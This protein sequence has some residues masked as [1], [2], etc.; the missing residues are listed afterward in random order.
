NCD[1]ADELTKSIK[2]FSKQTIILAKSLNEKPS[3]ANLNKIRK[4]SM[5][6]RNNILRCE[7]I[8]SGLLKLKGIA[9][10]DR[11]EKTRITRAEK[12]RLADK[13][14]GQCNFFDKEEL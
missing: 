5:T 7:S 9:D 10:N 8:Y 12:K 14:S 13:E 2:S 6:A 11:R 4:F 3:L 1:L